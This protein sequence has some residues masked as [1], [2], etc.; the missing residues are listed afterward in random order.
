MGPVVPFYGRVISGN[1]IIDTSA[2]YT[3]IGPSGVSIFSDNL[4]IE[5][6]VFVTGNLP[7]LGTVA[8]EGILPATGISAVSYDCGNGNVAI[9][10]AIPTNGPVLLEGDL[11]LPGSFTGCNSLGVRRL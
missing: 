4:L 10:E 6:P 3:R 11:G 5:G 8:L 7:F 2:P 1:L 9:I